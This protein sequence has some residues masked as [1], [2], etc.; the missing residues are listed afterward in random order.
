MNSR[1]RL[2]DLQDV[3][4]SFGWLQECEKVDFGNGLNQKQRNDRLML[5]DKK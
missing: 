5:F 4:I 3:K 2:V 1:L